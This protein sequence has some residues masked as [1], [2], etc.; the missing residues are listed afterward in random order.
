MSDPVAMSARSVKNARSP[1]RCVRHPRLKTRAAASVSASSKSPSRPRR[2]D[3]RNANPHRS[4]VPNRALNRVPNR[5]RNVRHDPNPSRTAAVS[6]PACSD[7][8]RP[9]GRH[10]S[11]A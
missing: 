2:R 1:A 5:A 11:N 4:R 3:A 8:G 6:A 7:P 9:I 10:S